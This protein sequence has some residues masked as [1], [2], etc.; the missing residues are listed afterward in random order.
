MATIIYRYIK[1]KGGDLSAFENTDISAF[2]DY[3]DIS[4]YAIDALCYAN[5]AGLISGRS[6]STLNPNGTATRA[7]AATVIMRMFDKNILA[8]K[9][10]E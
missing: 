1:F 4:D 9:A 7:E 8:A 6:E 2:D 5:G 3:G 10:A